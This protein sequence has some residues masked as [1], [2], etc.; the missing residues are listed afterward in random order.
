MHC[1]RLDH[2]ARIN[3]EGKISKCG[4][5][6]NAKEFDS[7]EEMQKSSWLQVK[8]GIVVNVLDNYLHGLRSTTKYVWNMAVAIM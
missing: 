4:H 8:I 5:M 2:F 1:P 7:F 6:T 3:H